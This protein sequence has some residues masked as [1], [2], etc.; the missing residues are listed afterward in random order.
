VVNG[1]RCGLSLIEA[2]VAMVI[3]GTG[4]LSVLALV[5]RSGSLLRLAEA[6][7]GAA[8]EAATVIDS[9]T[10]YGAPVAGALTR[11]RY[12]LSWTAVPDTIGVTLLT[13]AVGYDDGR[14][15]RADTF[16]AYAAP[17]PRVVRHA[18]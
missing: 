14:R 2:A 17:W 9:L 10:Q 3:L 4:L 6:E 11:G 16:I 5:A 13:V 15:T 1:R 7:E 12:A 18:P 8:H